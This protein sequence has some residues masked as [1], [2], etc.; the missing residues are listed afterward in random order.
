M[1]QYTIAI[2]GI[3]CYAYH[4]CLPEEAVIGNRYLVDVCIQANVSRSLDTDNLEDTIDYV[5]V[6]RIVKEEMAIR[7]NLIEHVAGRILKN[8]REKLPFYENL[9]VKVTKFNPP[10]NGNIRETS[11]CIQSGK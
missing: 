6:N 11:F 4:G 5:L 1:T 7:S 10:V 8:L 3:E 9:E 2:L